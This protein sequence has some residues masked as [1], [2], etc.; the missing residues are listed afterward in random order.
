MAEAAQDKAQ[1]PSAT[2]KKLSARLYAS[3]A[4]YQL[5]HTGDPVKQVFDQYIAD[6]PDMEID[7]EKLVEPD[8]AL[9]KKILFGAAEKKIDLAE[10]LQKALSKG[11]AEKNPNIDKLL[12]AILLCSAY[13]LLAHQDIDSPI[14][15]NDY[16]NVSHAFFDK[17]EISLVNGVLDNL[18]KALRD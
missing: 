8:G 4:M 1:K 17:G 10:M 7:G 16:L 11:D 5:L 12:Q 15:I 14:I 3:Q 13:E 6:A 2:A 18:S 9:F